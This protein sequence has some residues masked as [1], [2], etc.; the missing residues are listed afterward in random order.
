MKIGV[1]GVGNWGHRV[2]GEYIDL[3]NEKLIDDVYVC[4]SNKKILKEYSK[5]KNIKTNNDYVNLLESN[6]VDAIHVCVP[7]ILHYDVAKTAIENGVHVLMEKPLTKTSLEAYKLIELASERGI[8]LE[9]GHIYRFA[10]IMRKLKRMITE[11]YFGD[12]QYMTFKWTTKLNSAE[13]SA[14]KH[15]DIVW[16][17]MPHILDMIHFLTD[18]WPT[19][20]NVLRN[21]R[22]IS[23][24][25]LIYDDF[26]VNIELSWTTQ[27]RKRELRLIA[28]ERS[29]R[30][31]CVKQT[32]HVYENGKENDINPGANNTIREEALNFINSINNK[33]M[34]YNSHI[35]GARNVS[36]IEKI[37]QDN[38]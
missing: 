9:V 35:I 33:R 25:N 34:L 13:E 30:V 24:L 6:C 16:D 20:S 38:K 27:E 31:Q 36:V 1:I 14:L 32:M 10:N 21:G 2:I 23:F 28:S 15:V 12:I 7:N 8:V 18:K 11:D 3:K 4:E 19:E 37:L 29:A 17:L 26:L 5:N 22:Q